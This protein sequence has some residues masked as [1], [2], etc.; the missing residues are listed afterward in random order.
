MTR[1]A[2]LVHIMLATVLVGVLVIAVLATP[3]LR[4]QE[5]VF[6]PAACA[7]GFLLAIPL[8]AL[9]SRKLLALSRGA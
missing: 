9:I 6:I 8:S 7:L 4:G 5:K 2:A 1:L 3:S